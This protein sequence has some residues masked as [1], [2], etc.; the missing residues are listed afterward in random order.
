MFSCE[1][2]GRVG[3]PSGHA[4]DKSICI[5]PRG[6][7]GQIGVPQI[8]SAMAIWLEGMLLGVEG[9]KPNRITL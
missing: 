1:N 2:G 5:T 7:S 6:H 4:D 9:S 3:I 8:Y